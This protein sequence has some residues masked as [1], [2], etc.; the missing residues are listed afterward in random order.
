[1]SIELSISYLTGSAIVIKNNFFSDSLIPIKQRRTI[2]QMFF[3]PYQS[4][5]EFI[6]CAHHTLFPIPLL[7]FA[8][9]DP[10]VMLKLPAIMGG[11]AIGAAL[12]G[13]INKL[14]GSEKSASF[15]FKVSDHLINDFCQAMIDVVL[16]PLSTF[17]MLTRGISTG[18]QAA[19][20]YDYDAPEKTASLYMK[21]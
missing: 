7:G 15:F 2:G 19:G 18:L 16:L 20:I 21:K 13:S 10:I 4:Q 8:I 12:L 11:L 6:Y 1:M 9:L 17:V 14:C 3:Q 5:K